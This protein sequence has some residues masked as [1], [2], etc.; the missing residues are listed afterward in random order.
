MPY[1]YL[2]HCK[3]FWTIRVDSHRSSDNSN[4]SDS[5]SDSLSGKIKKKYKKKSTAD[6]DSDDSS[7]GQQLVIVFDRLLLS[8]HFLFPPT[9][10]L[11]PRCALAVCNGGARRNFGASHDESTSL[12]DTADDDDMVIY[13]DGVLPPPLPQHHYLLVDMERPARRARFLEEYC[14]LYG[15]TPPA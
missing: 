3:D 6:S 15:D 14:A 8:G 13:L 12:A 1:D 2:E 9:F 5:E 11:L 10:S 4:S 7:S